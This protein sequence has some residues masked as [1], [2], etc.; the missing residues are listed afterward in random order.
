MSAS[1][2]AVS[3]E[4]PRCPR[5]Q[6]VLPSDAPAGLCPACLVS[7]HFG[8]AADL[9]EP[10]APAAAAPSIDEL[11]PHFPQLEILACLGRGGMGVVYRARQ[12]SLGRLVAL[13]L[14]APERGGDPAFA[15]RF[16]REGQTLARLDH[17]HIVT[18]HDFGQAGGY[19]YLLM[20]FVDGVNLRQLIH[21]GRIAAREALAIVPQIC[22]AL[23]FAHD[24]GVVHRDIKPENILLDRRGQV[25]VADFGLAKLVGPGEEPADVSGDAAAGS[26]ADITAAGHVMGTPRYMAP[27]QRE[28]PNEVDHRADIYALGVVLYQMLTGE[29]PAEKQLQP[30]SR[31]VK[32][33]VRLDEVVL[34]ALEQDPGRRYTSADELKTRLETI[35]AE[36]PPL[37]RPPT[38]PARPADGSSSAKADES[39]LLWPQSPA[40][41]PPQSPPPPPP[42]ASSFAPPPPSALPSPEDARR[43]ALEKLKPAATA[44][45]V[46]SVFELVGLMLGLLFSLGLLFLL[47]MAGL[48]AG[49]ASGFST[50][51]KFWGGPLPLVGAVAGV[52]VALLAAW[53]ALNVAADFYV[54]SA[55]RRMFAGRD[56]RRARRGAVLAIVLGALGLLTAG[57][58]SGGAWFFG[59]WSVL[60]MAAGI[61]AFVLLRQPELI[62]AFAASGTGEAGGAG[63]GDPAKAARAAPT[64]AEISRRVN[65]PATGLIVAA[66]LQLLVIFV[67]LAVVGFGLL[68]H[69]GPMGLGVAEMIV[70]A[71]VMFVACLSAFV[72]VCAAR[73]R[74]LR[75]HGLAVCAAILAIIT[76]PGLLLGPIFGIWALVVLLRRDVRDAFDA[77]G[78]DAS[79]E[80]PASDEGVVAAP[81]VDPR[82]SVERLV[83]VP[84]KGLMVA[85]GLQILVC[86]AAL[87]FFLFFVKFTRSDATGT[88]ELSLPFNIFSYRTSTTPSS[89]PPA[90]YRLAPAVLGAGLL[91]SSLTFFAASRMRRL[92]NH[93]LAVCGALLA[94]LTLQGAGLGVV[95]GVWALAVLWR[96]EVH[97]AFDAGLA[98][99]RG[100]GCLL[101]VACLLL[102]AVFGATAGFVAHRRFAKAR[103]SRASVSFHPSVAPSRGAG[104]A[105]D[106]APYWTRSFRNL[107]ADEAYGLRSLRGSREFGG[108]A[109]EIGGQV[110]LL[111]AKNDGSS[112]IPPLPRAVTVPVG[113][114]VASLRLLHATQWQDPVG[115]EVATLRLVYADG[116]TR[117]QPLR[118]GVHV[119]DWQ[120]LPGEETE[121]LSDPASRIVWRGAG[122]PG[123]ETSA[124]AVLTTLVNPRPDQ[125]LRAL[126]IVSR[127]TLASYV[128]LGA[129]VSAE[130]W[131]AEPAALPPP[132][133][134][135]SFSELRL[136]VVDAASGAPLA[137]VFVDPGADGSILPPLFTDAA[138]VARLRYDPANSE[139][140]YVAFARAGCS[141]ASQRWETVGA[142]PA[143]LVVSL[144]CPAPSPAP[145]R[146]LASLALSELIA[147]QGRQ[148]EVLAARA[149][150]SPDLA[151]GL[152]DTCGELVGRGAWPG[153][154]TPPDGPPATRSG[155]G[156][157]PR[158]AETRARED[159]LV[160]RLREAGVLRRER[161]AGAAAESAALRRAVELAR[162]PG[163]STGVNVEQ[164][165]P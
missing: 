137:G 122:A 52:A 58:G 146:A 51:F 39:D 33:D 61:W 46:T 44:L 79:V 155:A 36:P 12:K 15:E 71:L 136:R 139:G 109:F 34:R 102:V 50:T 154:G 101:A 87:G 81:P 48:G 106:L 60:Q 125:E 25:K 144:E 98:R 4:A 164:S 150:Y 116:E 86:L 22:D 47:P 165:M 49:V 120:R 41:P 14:L 152:A 90:W 130:G 88:L 115:V 57:G 6:A 32:I 24:H 126:E 38:P 13:K 147:L 8:S 163:I 35:A 85:S 151:T 134:A 145:A 156:L 30:P 74:R 23:Q 94:I 157:D 141:G 75:G 89:G 43:V 128:L 16:A 82:V 78:V 93:G 142:I 111:G 124:R 37:A 19:Y 65:A 28:R 148:L 107:P 99:G 29:L 20:E 1:E 69:R 91:L 117:E 67:A 27:E 143:G 72:L 70:L 59:L 5:C 149:D 66:S 68:A 127:H 63:T 26:S 54:I 153:F 123:R 3:P 131:P 62:A 140:L 31:R 80:E 118:Y 21:G 42:P 162:K 132:G 53:L 45:I 55:A 104:G 110:V 2:A 95:F 77:K 129:A 112:S 97:R 7:A 135:R 83:S 103:A 133:T 84:A 11:A 159:E 40:S 113:R 76:F 158:E 96:R 138:G 73:M 10:A 9:T 119:L 18:I 56:L 161:G 121:P 108:Q 64:R 114:K 105:I 17:P 100:R 160:E 92:R